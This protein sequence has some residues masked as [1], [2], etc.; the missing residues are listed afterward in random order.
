MCFSKMLL[1]FTTAEFAIILQM[2]SVGVV[3]I[4]RQSKN[5][6]IGRATL[7]HRYFHNIGN[8]YLKHITTI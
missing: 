2:F 4:M 7:S 8:V 1:F 3:K 6:R 5:Y